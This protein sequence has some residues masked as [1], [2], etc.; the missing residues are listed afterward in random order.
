MATKQGKDKKDQN[1]KPEVQ[2]E[3]NGKFF[4]NT[5][6]WTLA[7]L[8]LVGTVVGNYYL[9]KHEG[10]YFEATKFNTFLQGFC[11]VVLI[12]LSVVIAAFTSTGKKVIIFSK[13]SYVEVRKVVWPTGQETRQ[14]TL[15]IGVVTCV[16]SLMLF[17]FDQIFHYFLSLLG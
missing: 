7:C 9:N 8:I 17:I 11:A 6:L 15:I 2:K 5:L 13:E 14:T 4:V 16:V 12:A 10:V 1:A 3:G